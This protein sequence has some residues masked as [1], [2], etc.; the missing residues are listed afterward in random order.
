ML[1]F[2]VVGCGHHG[3]N[4]VIPAITEH[5]E[6]CELAAVADV[7]PENFQQARKYPGVATYADFHEM[8]AAERLDAVYVCTTVEAHYDPVVAAFEAGLHVICEKPMA[9][10][11]ERCR[12][13]IAAADKADRRLAI[14]FENRY[15]PYVR[16]I[17]EWIAQGALGTVEAIHMQSF[18]DGHKAFGEMAERRA[19]FIDSSGAMDCGIHTVDLVRYFAGGGE[20]KDIHAVGAWF[21]EPRAKAPHL[22]VLAGLTSGPLA[23]INV[24]MGYTAQIRATASIHT[25]TIVGDKGVVDCDGYKDGKRCV[26]LTSDTLT[27]SIPLAGCGHLKAIGLLAD[28]FADVVEGRKASS[29]QLADGEDGLAAQIIVEEANAQALTRKNA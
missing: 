1:R 13:M 27:E 2:G 23:S 3:Q 24:S 16:K 12:R 29:E 28:D 14:T 6:H 26:T 19:R 10:S 25:M 15:N 20:W 21:G 5:R 11:V 18:W 7:N 22:S 9:D 4:V 8:I 17:R